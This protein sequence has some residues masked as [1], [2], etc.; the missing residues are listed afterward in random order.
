MKKIEIRHDKAGGCKKPIKIILGI[1]LAFMILPMFLKST[2][3]FG[4]LL[5]LAVGWAI[6]ELFL[7]SLLTK[8][9]Y[10]AK[11]VIPQYQNEDELK[12]IIN[13]KTKIENPFAG[14]FISGGAGSGKSKSLIEP[15]IKEAGKKGYT[16]VVYDF[17]FP[18][19]AQYVE[20]AYQ[21]SD[22]NR[23]YLNF[24]DLTKSN[25]INP[26]APELM[27]KEAYAREFAYSLL[28]NL[29]TSM[30]GK[31][32]FFFDNAVAFLTSI[33]WYLREKYPSYCTIPHAISIAVSDYE[34]VLTELSSVPRCADMIAPIMT[35]FESKAENQLSGQISSLQVELG[36]ILSD[37]V[38]YLL[39]GNEVDLRLNDSDKKGIL[40]LG[41]NPALSETYAPLLGV[42]LTSV[43]RQLNRQGKEKSIFM[44][45]E[46]PTIYIPNIEQLP[47]TARS[48]KVA[49]IL[50]CQDI[51][52]LN[53]RYG[54]EKTETILANL[55]NQFY[56]RT[57]NPTTAKRVS[58]IFGKEEKITISKTKSPSLFDLDK[59]ELGFDKVSKTYATRETDVVK[60][61]HVTQLETGS[62]YTILS[63]GKIKQGLS[64]IP[65][66]KSFK[67]E[68]ILSFSSTS[69]RDIK[70]AYNKVTRDVQDVILRD[71]KL[72]L[73][74]RKM[75]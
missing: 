26:I 19:L 24:D 68:E 15:L 63:E 16:G 33:F 34:T 50:A 31:K 14:I 69:E 41:N 59:G 58:E 10:L 67:K 29:N 20:S 38:Y 75:S 9:G 5:F 61:Q 71:A 62:F 57:P 44:I 7:K 12:F 11:S 13:G 42:I 21:N 1:F 47:A 70:N 23:Y 43:A 60:V 52:Q 56:G 27:T 30:V 72:F 32:E 6:Y 46:F 53:D 51:A 48:N 28:I 35:A 73:K 64:Q 66:D 18:E 40:C 22:I 4:L 65:M 55:G 36:K 17:K 37:E 49:T 2:K 25:R 45:D 54:R 39:S 3:V 8:G 74:Q